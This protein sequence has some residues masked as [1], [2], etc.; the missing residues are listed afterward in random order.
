ML[1]RSDSTP[2]LMHGDASMYKKFWKPSSRKMTRPTGIAYS[3]AFLRSYLLTTK[4]RRR[5]KRMGECLTR[6]ISLNRLFAGRSLA[7]LRRVPRKIVKIYGQ[8]QYQILWRN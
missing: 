8:S 2:F 4:K 5:V 7:A 1:L 6:H 3:Q